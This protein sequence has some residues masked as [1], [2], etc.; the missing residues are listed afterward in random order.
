MIPA[1]LLDLTAGVAVPFIKKILGDKLGGAG[2]DLAGSV[3]DIV[4]GKLGVPVDK[5]PEQ[6]PEKIQEALVAA[7]PEAAELV[8]AH[9][10]SQ[11][12]ANELALA[13]MAKDGGTWAWA[14]RPF[15][16]WL[17]LGLVPYYAVIVPL[18]NAFMA[19][20]MVLVL[21]VASFGTLLMFYAGF[22]MGGHTVKAAGASLLSA[23]RAK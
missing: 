16:M 7:E 3:I 14:W 9:V 17:F 18:I 5:I 10:E 2:G 11:R 20:P 15:G 1:I 8:L 13:E 19:S 12:L 22:Y 23:W 21:D 4:A 6:P